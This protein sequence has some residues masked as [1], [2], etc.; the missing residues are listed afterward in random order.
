MA[1]SQARVND[2][3]GYT[4]CKVPPRYVLDFLKLGP[5]I[6][7]VDTGLSSSISA[8]NWAR[9]ELMSTIPRGTA[10]GQRTGQWVRPLC[11]SLAV[12]CRAPS[13]VTR[14]GTIRLVIVRCQHPYTTASPVEWFNFTTQNGVF[15]S[16]SPCSNY[17]VMNASNIE[18][19]WDS[20]QV[21]LQP[22]FGAASNG[23]S[24]SGPYAFYVGNYVIPLGHFITTYQEG[25]GLPPTEDRIKTNAV[26]CLAYT[27]ESVSA[28]M[29]CQVIYESA[30][31]GT[32]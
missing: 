1:D 22:Y 25:T 4:L 32:C 2:G 9:F 31:L 15:A 12:R 3:Q 16:A 13:T 20:G 30:N 10:T 27:E 17:Q 5:N 28:A 18:V 14:H 24:A 29:L 8:N 26:Y 21:S 19:L 11:I 6:H 7:S 23:T